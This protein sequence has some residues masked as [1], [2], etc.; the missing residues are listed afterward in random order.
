MIVICDSVPMVYVCY[1]YVLKMGARSAAE[2]PLPSLPQFCS[3]NRHLWRCQQVAT[4]DGR[5]PKQPRG[6]IN[7]N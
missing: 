2:S 3:A 6:C 5:N 7:P 1:C 4:V